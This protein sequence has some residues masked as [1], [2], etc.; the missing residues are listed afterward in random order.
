M[1]NQKLIALLKKYAPETQCDCIEQLDELYR[2]DNPKVR[3]VA[4]GSYN[5]GKSS[6]LNSLTGEVESEFFPIKDIPETRENKEFETCSV[7]YVDTPGLDVND[8]DTSNALKGGNRGDV[9]LFV[10]KLTSG[11]LQHQDLELM[12]EIYNK[13]DDPNSVLFILTAGESAKKNQKVIEEVKNQVGLFLSPVIEVVLVS[14]TTFTKGVIEKKPKLVEISG[15]MEIREIVDEMTQSIKGS[16]RERRETKIKKLLTDL[17]S[18][19]N[20][21]RLKLESEKQRVIQNEKRF[22]SSVQNLKRK[23]VQQLKKIESL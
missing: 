10:H 12:N 17:Y 1:K 16:V 22:I 20:K 3:V 2:E 19:V 9:L 11:S 7:L 5:S 23:T 14:N 21:Q 8:S 4:F 18:M 6:L 13:H 15:V